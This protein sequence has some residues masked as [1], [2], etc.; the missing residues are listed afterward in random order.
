MKE[1]DNDNALNEGGEPHWIGFESDAV[2]FL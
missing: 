1:I 2:A